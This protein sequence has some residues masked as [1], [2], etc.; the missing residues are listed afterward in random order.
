[1]ES[2]RRTRKSS[3]SAVV[4]RRPTTA[5][6]SVRLQIGRF[7]SIFVGR[8]NDSFS[9]IHF[10][11]FERPEKNE[12][13]ALLDPYGFGKLH[14]LLRKRCV[15]ISSSTS[16]VGLGFLSRRFTG[17]RRGDVGVS[18]IL[19][20]LGCSREWPAS[21][22]TSRMKTRCKSCIRNTHIQSREWL[23]F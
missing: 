1:M 13:S 11:L 14:V 5:R 16:G 3:R 4:A 23:H 18:C 6:R 9:G 8:R 19:H 2:M 7:I 21:T 10:C 17:L 20:V 12:Q 22:A 15:F